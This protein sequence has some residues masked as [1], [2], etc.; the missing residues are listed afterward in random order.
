MHLSFMKSPYR[1]VEILFFQPTDATGEF[2]ETRQSINK[3]HSLQ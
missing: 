1:L 2:R 3:T